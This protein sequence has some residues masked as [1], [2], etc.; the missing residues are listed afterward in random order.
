MSRR[1][2]EASTQVVLT[3]GHKSLAG[4]P[5]TCIDLVAPLLTYGQLAFGAEAGRV[6]HQERQ[7]SVFRLDDDRQ[8]VIPV[9]CLPR[10]LSVLQEAGFQVDIRD[11]RN[12]NRESLCLADHDIAEGETRCPGITA[13]MHQFTEG[14]LAVP[15]GKRR[16]HAMGAM[17]RLLSK[18]R[19]FITCATKERTQETAA[20]LGHYVGG[21]VQA[22]HGGTWSSPCRVVCGTIASFNTSQSCDFDMLI[23]EDAFEAIAKRTHDNRGAFGRHRVYAFVDPN[24]KMNNKRRLELEVLAGPPIF[25]QGKS[26]HA[27]PSLEVAFATVP[28]EHLSKAKSAREQREQVWIAHRRNQTI[29]GIARACANKNPRKLWECGLFL[30]E[31]DPFQRWASAPNVTILTETARHAEDLAAL[32]PDWA[33]LTRRPVTAPSPILADAWSRWT[34]PDRSIVTAVRG[35]DYRIFNVDVIVMAAGG[36]CPYLPRGLERRGGHVLVVDFD[37][38]GNSAS[39]RD[40]ASRRKHYDRLCRRDI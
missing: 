7:I 39:L 21:A 38:C 19:I 4:L 34:V 25:Q 35:E 33:V 12:L 22:V 40:V 11:L 24:L 27:P 20:V 31:A 32:L 1:D 17:C 2:P 18:A 5:I 9:G 8:M 37:D 28:E 13:C 26:H 14:V 29:A 15:R 3:I 23:F 10:I 6:C 30:D 36:R 16:A